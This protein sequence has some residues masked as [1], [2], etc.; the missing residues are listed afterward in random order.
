MRNVLT[1]GRTYSGKSLT[2]YLL[3]IYGIGTEGRVPKEAIFD[4]VVN[5][6]PR[7]KSRIIYLYNA[8]VF[9]SLWDRL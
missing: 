9:K 2:E 1:N 7:K 5:V 8:K 6:L 4:Y 3:R